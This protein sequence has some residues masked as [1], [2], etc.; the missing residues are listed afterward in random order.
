M[1]VIA[2]ALTANSIPDPLKIVLMDNATKSIV[3]DSVTYAA[4]DHNPGV[5]FVLNAPGY[6]IYYVKLLQMNPGNP[7]G[8]QIAAYEKDLTENCTSQEPDLEIVVDGGRTDLD[9]VSGTDT[10]DIPSVAGRLYRVIQRGLGQLMRAIEVEFIDTGGFKLVG[11]VFASNQAYFIQYFPPSTTADPDIIIR[12]NSGDLYAP[13]AGATQYRNPDLKGKAFRVV[14]RGLGPMLGTVTAEIQIVVAGGF[15]LLNGAQFQ[16]GEIFFVQVYPK[17]CITQT[18]GG[19]G[20]QLFN[21]E[22]IIN[23]DTIYDGAHLNKLIVFRGAGVTVQYELPDIISF[24][25]HVIMCF[26]ANGGSQVYGAIATKP[27]QYIDYK[28]PNQLNTIRIGLAQ[29]EQVWI[30]KGAAGK[31]R[32]LNATWDY[33]N[34]GMDILSNGYVHNTLH[35]NGGQFPKAVYWRLWDWVLENAGVSPI[36]NPADWATDKGYYCDVDVDNFRVPDDSGQVYKAADTA[37]RFPGSKETDQVGEINITLQKGDSYGGNSAA[38]GK[39]APGGNHQPTDTII[40]NGGKENTVKNYGKIAQ[41][42]F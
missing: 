39:F 40:V 22:V 24:P 5:N 38:P 18:G 10:V 1:P 17:I 31:W 30:C 20:G 23:A 7:A 11:N 2:D 9:P 34:V 13:A 33:S 42:K 8:I 19:A 6:D 41:V 29:G 37:I 27:G 12:V 36:K 32:V 14:S 25:P 3:Y 28:V 4:V 15:D 21:D 26:E 16:A 35:K